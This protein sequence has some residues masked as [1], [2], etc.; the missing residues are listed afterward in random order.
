MATCEDL[1][2]PETGALCHCPLGYEGDGFM[3]GTGCTIV[4]CSPQSPPTNGGVSGGNSYG[5]LATFT[6][7]I[8]YS[9]VGNNP[10]LCQ[11]DGDWSGT[12]PTC[13]I[14]QC[15]PQSPP[16][17]GAVSGGNSYG[18]LATFTC[19]IGYSLVGNNPLL[20]QADGT[21]SGT[22]PTCE[23]VQC[24]P[25]SPPANGAVSG[26][27]SY[28]DEATFT[29]DTGYNLVGDNPLLCQ[30]DGTWSGPA[31]TC[32][33]VQCS[34][35]S[36]PTN[37]GVSG[38]NSYGDVAT[39]TCDTGYNLV[40]DNPLLCQ[41]DGTWS[42]TAPTCEIVQCS[43][44]SP[45]TNGAVSG[46]NSYGDLATF[47]C[48]TGYNL[49]GDNPLL[50]QAD[51]TWSGTAPT[52]EI[53]QCSPQSPPTNGAVSG[54]NS[55]GDLATFTCD[56]GYNLVGDN[57][58]LCQADGTW[59][60]AIPPTC[61]DTNGCDPDP[62]VAIATC[63]DNEAPMTGAVCT[64]PP[65]YHGDGKVHG[66]GCTDIPGCDP[67]PCHILATCEDVPAPD[68]GAVCICPSGYEGDGTMGGTGCTVVQCSPQ[69]PPTNGGVSGGNS[70][71]DEAT[72]TCDPGYYLVGVNPLVCQAD[73]TW[74]DS[75]P[76]C[77]DI[78]GCNPDP[79]VPMAT[80]EDLPPPQTGALCHCP[81]G[82]EGD[83]F[84]DGTGCTNS[85]CC[86]EHLAA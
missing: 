17:N 61:E 76:T 69:S 60:P 30:A 40:G 68:T 65:G 7:D 70:Y 75:A 62:C 78:N 31:P 26:G 46:G 35:Q 10:L 66:T 25:Q 5:D 45:P 83:G 67:N 15:S 81:L 73:G 54:G 27:N 86:L 33:I 84:M 48:D 24:S 23:I 39:F 51:G 22:A 52:C 28:G 38:G 34:P 3:D 58:L 6:C 71:G 57:P 55:Y 1:P 82:Y 47:T 42:G 80:C 59:S 44:Q 37:G 20:C 12:A 49:V 79:C 29:C 43:P 85:E 72:F 2:P 16:T 63:S 14:V 50:C 36:P 64:C 9:L 53:V 74:S 11:A 4:Q 41:A 56:T 32:E 18:D 13:E 77:E 19:D 21:W 8:G